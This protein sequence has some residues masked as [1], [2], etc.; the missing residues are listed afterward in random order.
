MVSADEPFPHRRAFQRVMITMRAGDCSGVVVHGSDELA[1]ATFAGRLL[2]RMDRDL[3]RVVVA[4]QF[5]AFAILQEIRVQTARRE[6]DKIVAANAQALSE[7]PSHF[8]ATLRELIEGPCQSAASGAFVLVLHGFDPI[9]TSTTRPDERRDLSPE[10]LPVARGLIGAFAGARTESRLLF[11][12][13][14][15]F[16]VTDSNGDELAVSLRVESL[17][18]A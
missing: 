11:T 18:I 3:S 16:S 6:I 12:S 8:L 17:G 1:R 9:T 10:L 15:P 14:A 2:R 7:D 4:R 5:D 13:T